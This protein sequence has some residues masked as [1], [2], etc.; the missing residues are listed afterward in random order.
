MA[1]RKVK[2][3]VD[4]DGMGLIDYRV[5]IVKMSKEIKEFAI[6]LS[7]SL[8]SVKMAI[9]GAL[10]LVEEKMRGNEEGR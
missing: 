4:R 9:T 8:L 2:K 6:K 5:G 10:R 1:K 7:P 3:E